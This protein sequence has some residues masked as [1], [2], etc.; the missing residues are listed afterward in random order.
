MSKHNDLAWSL[1]CKGK[2]EIGVPVGPSHSISTVA[3]QLK[4]SQ[5]REVPQLGRKK[6]VHSPPSERDD[7]LGDCSDLND[8]F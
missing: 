6:V 2:I 1:T 7:E 4:E 5:G 3:S 8:N